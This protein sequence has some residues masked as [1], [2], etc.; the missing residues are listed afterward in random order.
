MA[1]NS[2]SLE[3]ITSLVVLLWKCRQ[4]QGSPCPLASCSRKD[5]FRISG[6]WKGPPE[7][8]GLGP[9]PQ[10]YQGNHHPGIDLHSGKRDHK[11]RKFEVYSQ[12]NVRTLA[13]FTEERMKLLHKYGNA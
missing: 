4:I 6:I 5:F 1:D 3:V 8:C 9:C 12:E 10:R 7:A 2:G 13:G 11:L